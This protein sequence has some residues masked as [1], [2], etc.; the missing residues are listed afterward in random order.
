MKRIAWIVSS[1]YSGST[2]L[3][4]LLDQIEGVVSMG[5]GARAYA[6][7][8]SEFKG[9]C[10][11]CHAPTPAE[12]SLYKD[13]EPSR[14]VEFGDDDWLDEQETAMVRHHRQKQDDGTI[15]IGQTFY[16]FVAEKYPNERVMVDATKDPSQMLGEWQRGKK[17]PV[18]ALFI[19]KTPLEAVSSY[20]GHDRKM[21]AADC[22]SE[23][24]RTNLFYL[25]FLHINTIPVLPLRYKDLALQPN[26][27]LDRVCRFL[28]I[29]FSWRVD[30]ETP[31][32]HM[33]GGNPAVSCV[34]AGQDRS[35]TA[36]GETLA[37]HMGGKYTHLNLNQPLE[38]RY[39]DSSRHLDPR[40]RLE[41][42]REID[43]HIET[44]PGLLQMMGYGATE[45]NLF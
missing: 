28:Q 31:L 18:R 25:A 20:Y 33:L 37:D 1:A 11:T 45:L 13:W 29:P 16:E 3:S 14:I 39:D 15:R 42:Q 38:V 19:S 10:A 41:C 22:V 26:A 24:M 32:G 7:P 2:L 4:A 9:P 35:V 23:Y 27:T 36:S 43:R 40:F 30:R 44:L 6:K 17:F 8:D 5:E 12:C 34:V 21:T